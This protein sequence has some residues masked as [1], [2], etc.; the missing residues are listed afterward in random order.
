MRGCGRPGRR[1]RGQDG[2]GRGEARA[3]EGHAHAIVVVQHRLD[4]QRCHQQRRDEHRRPI[5]QRDRDQDRSGPGDGDGPHPSH[6]AQR[7]HDH[8]ERRRCRERQVDLEAVRRRHAAAGDPRDAHDMCPERGK[9]Q[10][11][12]EPSAG[13]RLAQQVPCGLQPPDE[14]PRHPNM[15]YSRNRHCARRAATKKES[16][17]RGFP[18]VC[19]HL[20]CGTQ[21]LWNCNHE[22]HHRVGR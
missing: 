13:H 17:R 4:Q 2:Q 15:L 16:V 3:A 11:A 21:E 7:E 19:D 12:G 1:P 5:Q 9:Q 8:R 10:G 14:K 6:V 22:E 20:Y 18:S